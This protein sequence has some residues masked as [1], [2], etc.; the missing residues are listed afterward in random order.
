M[1]AALAAGAVDQSALSN[2]IKEQTSKDQTN[3]PERSLSVQFS[4]LPL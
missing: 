3:E 4:S 2:K 1:F